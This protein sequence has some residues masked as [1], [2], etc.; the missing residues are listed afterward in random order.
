[1]LPGLRSLSNPGS[2]TSLHNVGMSST[3]MHKSDYSEHIIVV[4]DHIG[5]APHW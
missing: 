2:V 4:A 5:A 1:M 3:G